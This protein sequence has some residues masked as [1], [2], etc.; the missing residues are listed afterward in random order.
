L[1]IKSE[2]IDGVARA[3]LGSVEKQAQTASSGDVLSPII[4]LS[5]IAAVEL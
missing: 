1:E 4:V 3:G 5:V 2:Y